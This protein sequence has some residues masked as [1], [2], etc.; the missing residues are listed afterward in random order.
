M[1]AGACPLMQRTALLRR[2]H[3]YIGS[4]EASAARG[5]LRPASA[6][7]RAQASGGTDWKKLQSLLMQLRKCCN[8][9]FLFSGALDTWLIRRGSGVA[10]YFLGLLLE[11][12]G[13]D[14][15]HE[16]ASA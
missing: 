4:G 9:P 14:G 3:A 13:G 10:G 1:G 11:V 7:A 15:G 12:F 16:L 5:H 8:H 6:A 2:M